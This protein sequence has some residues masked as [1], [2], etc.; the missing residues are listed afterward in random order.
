MRKKQHSL[1]DIFVTIQENQ[2]KIVNT[3]FKKNIIVQGCAG[4]GKTMVLLHR[5][6]A[7]KYKQRYFDFSQNALILTPNEEFSLHIQGLAE[8]LQIGSVHRLSVEQY[9]LEMLLQYDA[10]F[11]PENKI[12]SEMQVRQDYVD[13]IYSDQFKRDFDQAYNSILA[14]RNGLVDILIQLQEAMGLENNPFSWTDESRFTVQM[15]YRVDTLNDLVRKKEQDVVS[16]QE[17]I[18]KLEERKAFLED[19]I[20]ASKHFAENIVQESL[21]RVNT[22]IGEYILEKQQEITELNKKIQDLQEEYTRIQGTLIMFGKR[23][24]LEKLDADIKEVEAVVIPLQ[25]QL[26]EQKKILSIEQ[27]GKEDDEI[28][29]WMKQVSIYVK[30]VQDEVRLCSNTKDEYSRF[31]NELNET[32]DNIK[33]AYEEYHRIDAEQYSADIKKTVQYLYEQLE[34]YSLL[35]I[36]HQIYDES[37]RV[38]KETN[39]IKSITGKCHRYDL[40]IQ[41]MFAMRY[42]NKKIGNMQFI[43]VDEGQDLAV[44]EYRLLLELNQ[45]NVVFNIFGDTNQLMKSGRGIADWSLMMSEFHAEQYVLNEN[46]R[47]TNQITRFCNDNF[48]LQTLQTGVD[49]SKV[50]EI[51]RR[52][53]EKELAGLKVTTERVAILLPR[54]VQKMKYLDMDILPENTRKIIGETM[55]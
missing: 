45:N 35:N 30:K 29:A 34:Q 25:Q 2:N 42:F 44:N 16:A 23:S 5:L 6:S 38:F 55:G 7:L 46:Y 28:L 50:R 17:K 37:V 9:Y 13:Y 22:K 43:C 20:P 3:D 51:P 19:R 4:S 15:K 8:G 31:S 36:Y 11:K 1:T 26:D 24:R 53:L 21:P 10:A 12:V 49:G 27:E 39:A 54:T 32:V 40:Y 14:K 18:T 52:D 48:G 33:I 47:N 41:L